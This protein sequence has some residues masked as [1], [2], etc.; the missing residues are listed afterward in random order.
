MRR[1]FLLQ[2][3]AP[4]CFALQKKGKSSKVAQVVFLEVSCHRTQDDV[5]L[6]GKLLLQSERPVKR[7]QLRIDFFSGDKQL[8]SSKRGEVSEEEMKAGDESEFHMRVSHPPASVYYS[9]RAEDHDGRELS[10]ERA[11]PFPIE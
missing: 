10:V 11:G 3:L 5:A 6:D 7:L 1:Y 8:I 2:L 4:L 9:L